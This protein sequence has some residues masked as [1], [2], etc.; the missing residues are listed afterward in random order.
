MSLHSSFVLVSEFQFRLK[1]GKHHF[2]PESFFEHARDQWSKVR[3]SDENDKTCQECFSLGSQQ[4]LLTRISQFVHS[5]DEA[6]LLHVKMFQPEFEEDFIADLIKSPNYEQ[7]GK[8]LYDHSF[9]MEM[10]QLHHRVRCV[11]NGRASQPMSEPMSLFFSQYVQPSLD[12]EPGHPI[13]QQCLERLLK[14][15][16]CDRQ[17][18]DFEMKLVKDIV[19]GTL[20]QHPAIQ[21]ILV[22]CLTKVRAMEKGNTTMRSNSR[23]LAS[24]VRAWMVFWF[25]KV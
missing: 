16:S 12:T 2:R 20:S 23:I 3:I 4:R 9:G 17:T 1:L 10:D 19:T 11:W 25:S 14:Y 15:M 21:G 13:K 18:H 8:R 24:W 6:H 5:M 7:R 22:A